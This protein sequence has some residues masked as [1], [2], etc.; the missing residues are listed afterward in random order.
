MVCVGFEGLTPT[1]ELIELIDRGVSSVILF[2]RNYQSPAQLRELCRNLKCAA[3]RPIMICIDQEGGR[4]QRLRDASGSFT[5]IPS[6]REIGQMGDEQHARQI[7]G[8]L[9]CELRRV[10]IDM[11]LAPVLDVDSNPHNPVI[12]ERSLG[13]NPQAVARLGCALIDGLQSGPHC[14]AACGKHFPG[15]GDTSIDSHL[16][17]PR[18]PHDLERLQRIELP[19]FEA[20]IQRGVASIMVSHVLFE[21]LDQDYPASMSPAIID[22]LLRRRLQFDRVVIA[23]D[24]EMK[25]IVD[26]FG[27]EEAVIRGASAGVDLFPICHQPQRQHLAID[28]LVRAA[29]SGAV[30]MEHIERSNRRLDSLCSRFVKSPIEIIA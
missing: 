13:N 27:I 29:R 11:N 24:L 14:V 9:A 4:V 15:H 16:D 8:T 30:P 21:P 7:G 26:H 17:L 2:S 25:A 23:D 18:L 10:N 22:G 20:A 12:G 1:A 28:A 6:M 19:P 5:A 3:D